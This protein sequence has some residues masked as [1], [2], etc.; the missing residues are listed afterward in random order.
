MPRLRLLSHIAVLAAFAPFGLVLAGCESANPF[1]G[2]EDR[3]VLVALAENLGGPTPGQAARQ[4]FDR[5]DPDRRRRAIALLSSADWGGEDRY[6]AV[7]RLILT[8]PDPTVRAACVAALGR[9]G[10]AGDALLIA[11]QFAAD[12]AFLRW[13]SA[14][15]L[16]QL[17]NPLVVPRLI[18]VLQTDE[19]PDTRMAAAEA[20]GQY[21]RRDVFDALVSS[22]TEPEYGIAH[23]A[24][25]SLETLTGH[26]AGQEPT[27]WHSWAALH[28][29]PSDLFANAR[30]YTYR[31]Y[32]EPPGL[33]DRA[34]FWRDHEA[35]AH[36]RPAGVNQES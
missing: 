6:L 8:D 4:A 13:E 11:N 3:S 10:D 24:H 5:E 16:R 35:E 22:L 31:E 15:A 19:D 21:P 2:A 28:T 29:S 32:V 25:R 18:A 36:R 20:L 27:D 26:D 30:P 1:A 7:Y 34:Q 33:I 17:H 14:K 12:E 23:A 9:H